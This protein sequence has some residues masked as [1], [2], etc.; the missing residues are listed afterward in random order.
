MVSLSQQHLTK[1]THQ[2]TMQPPKSRPASNTKL[3]AITPQ[4]LVSSNRR[5]QAP[6]SSKKSLF[7]LEKSKICLFL[8]YLNIL[9]LHYLAE[10]EHR[11]M[12][13]DAVC[14]TLKQF[15]WERE[16]SEQKINHS[17]RFVNLSLAHLYQ[18]NRK[19]QKMWLENLVKMTP[20]PLLFRNLRRCLP[21]QSHKFF[22]RKMSSFKIHLKNQKLLRRRG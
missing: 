12:L 4:W 19:Q 21:H 15:C 13:K 16:V 3:F 11:Q 17:Q 6:D 8:H 5:T 22:K 2:K 1:S 14:Q 18:R 20:N 10:A 7:N 9:L